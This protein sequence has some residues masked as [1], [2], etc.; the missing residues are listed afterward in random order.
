MQFNVNCQA[1]LAVS[2]SKMKGASLARLRIDP[3]PAA[4]ELHH[5]FAMRQPDARAFIIA[6][7]V[8]ALEDD[9]N[10]FLVLLLYTYTIIAE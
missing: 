8:E 1:V 7:V 4:M 5:F 10:P 9:K 3:D 2:N 6:A